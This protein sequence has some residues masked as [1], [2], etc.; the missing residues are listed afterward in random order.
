MC[1]P[2]IPAW[3]LFYP[4]YE[5]KQYVTNW[6]LVIQIISLVFSFLMPFDLK[7]TK[8]PWKMALNHLLITLSVLLH[9]LIFVMYWGVIWPDVYRRNLGMAGRVEY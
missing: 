8:K 7:Y 2:F 1:I 5:F 3:L 6:G 9:A 4:A